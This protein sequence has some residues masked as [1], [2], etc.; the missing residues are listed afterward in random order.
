MY[1]TRRTGRLKLF[2]KKL[3]T[4]PIEGQELLRAAINSRF[5]AMIETLASGVK[6]TRRD[7]HW[8]QK[9]CTIYRLI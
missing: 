1:M 4:K 2:A 5:G 7:T 8:L 3:K 9:L 6:S